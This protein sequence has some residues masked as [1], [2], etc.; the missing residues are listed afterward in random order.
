[1]TRLGN[2]AAI[3]GL[4]RN[5]LSTA[6]AVV[7]FP[8]RR[9]VGRF[10]TRTHPP[11]KGSSLSH[12]QARGGAGTYQT[13]CRRA[14]LLASGSIH[15]PH[16]RVRVFV[17]GGLPFAAGPARR[18]G[19][20]STLN[21][22]AGPTNGGAPWGRYGMLSAR[23]EKISAR[24]RPLGTGQRRTRRTPRATLGQRAMPIGQQPAGSRAHGSARTVP[25]GPSSGPS[26][27]APGRGRALGRAVAPGQQLFAGPRQA[28]SVQAAKS[29]CRVGPISEPE[30]A[31][32]VADGKQNAGATQYRPRCRA[33]S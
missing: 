5:S 22:A 27:S 30:T 16:A 15:A 14:F 24:I 23:R 20:A 2:A 28:R 17:P 10:T 21:N 32:P 3:I 12:G 33:S 18:T 25:A 4:P 7:R 11:P 8:L 9:C 6:R 26:T 31:L 19:L 29:P 13:F 1:M